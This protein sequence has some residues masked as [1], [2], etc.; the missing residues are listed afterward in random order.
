[1]QLERAKL[2]YADKQQRARGVKNR[3]SY[4]HTNIEPNLV[5]HCNEPYLESF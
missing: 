4:E 3:G 5:A 1:M 2:V